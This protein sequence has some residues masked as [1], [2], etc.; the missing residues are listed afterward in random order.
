MLVVQPVGLRQH[1]LGVDVIIAQGDEAGGY[2]GAIATLALVPQVVDAVHPLPVVAAGGIADGRGLAAAM[3]LGAV[4]VNVG[5]RFLASVEAHISPVWKQMIVDAAA[6]DAVLVEV[7]NDIMPSPGSFG[8]G[9]VLR[10][11]RTPFIDTWQGRRE[12]AKRD[13]ERLR[14][15]VL[16]VFKQMRVHKLFP[17]AGQSA[18]LI[19]DIV[20]AGEIVRRIVTE[21][22]RAL[23]HSSAFLT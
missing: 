19:R 10:A 21:A 4:G 20:P 15:E 6:E 9:T 16:P 5:T 7:L 2:V 8:Y 3:V 18:G 11:L 22:R 14:S 17:G 23:E 13:A 12:E 1:L